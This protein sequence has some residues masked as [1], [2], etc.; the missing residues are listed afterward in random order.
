MCC[1]LQTAVIFRPKCRQTN[2][3]AGDK[4]A[5]GDDQDGDGEL[6]THMGKALGAGD[7]HQVHTY[8]QDC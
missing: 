4:F 2:V 5:L 6:L 7:T 1:H 8:T 3:D